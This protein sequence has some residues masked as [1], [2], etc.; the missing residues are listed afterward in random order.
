MVLLVVET[1]IL[2]DSWAFYTPSPV[3]KGC[4]LC[5][6]GLKIRNLKGIYFF[7]P[8]VQLRVHTRVHVRLVS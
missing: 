5:Q 3:G 6:C 7:R 2:E 1:R 8:R 4:M